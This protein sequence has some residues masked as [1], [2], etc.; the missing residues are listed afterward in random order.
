MNFE[1]KSEYLKLVSRVLEQGEWRV[2]P[3]TS[4]QVCT[5]FSDSIRYELDDETIPVVR[6]KKV[7]LRAVLNELN[8]FLSGSTNI[9]DLDSKIWNEWANDDGELGPVYGKQWVDWNGTNQIQN[10]IT[11]LYKQPFARRHIVSAW[12]VSDLP[13]MALSPCHMM[14]QCYVSN[15]YRLHMK[16]YQRSADLFLGVPFNISSYGILLHAL[17]NIL[18]YKVGSLEIT[19]GDVHIYHNHLQAVAR[20]FDFDKWPDLTFANVSASMINGIVKA[21]LY[22]PDFEHGPFIPAPIA[23]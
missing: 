2:E 8:W 4:E 15:D 1:R 19:F 21:D 23:V 16:M 5:K 11:S 7:N 14:F 3:R 17:A 10:L 9:K 18:D 22:Y 20:M 6:C 12:N 13:K